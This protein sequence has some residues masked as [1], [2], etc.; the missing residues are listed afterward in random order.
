[1]DVQQVTGVD[2]LGDAIDGG[3]HILPGSLIRPLFAD[4][5]IP[6]EVVTE[7]PALPDEDYPVGSLVFLTVDAKLYRNVDGSTWSRAVDGADLITDSVT[8]GQIAAGAIGTNELA[9]TLVLASLLTTAL[10]G[11]RVEIDAAGIR[12]ISETDELLVNIPTEASE[13]VYV[14]G[15]VD[16]AS[17]ISRAYAELRG[18]ATLAGGSVL[19]V[20][21]GVAA[22]TVPPILT[23]TLDSLTLT[24]SPANA[25]Y[26][27]FY[28]AAAGSFWVGAD[29]T[30]GSYI[31]H[32][33]NATTGVLIRSI[34]KNG[35]I[36]T[37]TATRGQ[38]G[39][40]SDSAE[41]TSGSTDSQICTGIGFPSDG[42][43]KRITRVH[44]YLAG[45]G[46]SMSCKLAVWHGDTSLLGSS[47]AFT[48]AQ[49]TFSAGNSDL[50]E[51]D[52]TA[53]V[54]VS[55][56]QTIY[57]G[58]LRTTG[59]PGFWW[60]KDNS[61]A[62][63]IEGDGLDGPLTN[64][65]T[66]NGVQPNV[67]VTY[68]Y[69]VS[70]QVEVAKIIGVAASASVVAALGAD[71]ILHRYDRS[72]LTYIGATDL[73]AQIG[74]TEANAGLTFDGT[75]F[76]ITTATGTGSSVQVRLVKVNTSGVHQSN[77]NCTGFSING[78]T[79]TIRGGWY[80]GS[81]NF[82][83]NVNGQARKYTYSTGAYVSNNEFGSAASMQDGLA[84][85]GSVFRGWA[86]ATPTKVW[87]F[88]SWD[89]TTQSALY[90][91]GYSWYDSAG[92]THE[93]NLSPRAS[94]TM[95]RRERLRV[96]TPEIPVGGADEPNQVRVYMDRGGTDPGAGNFHR[97]VTDAL[98]SRFLSTFDS[99]GA[100]DPTSNG[101]PAGSPAEVRSSLAPGSGGWSFKGSGQ[102]AMGG[103]SFPSSP[104]T[105]DLFYRTDRDVLYFYDG[106][107]WLSV[108][109]HLLFIN[110]WP[111]AATP[112]TAT[113]ST[114]VGVIP[115]LG[116]HSDIWLETARI[117]FFV[118]GGTALSGSH[119]WDVNTAKNPL[120][121]ASSTTMQSHAI[122]SGT[123]DVWRGQEIAVNALLNSGTA[124]TTI[125][126]GAT[127]TGTPG[128]LYIDWVYMFRFVG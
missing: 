46:G 59:S 87:K 43:P 114:H 128:A 109:Q 45:F 16:A 29:P 37:Y 118:Q 127:K 58:F 89:W 93:T 33:Y 42:Y 19:T 85:D 18:V 21:N 67:W 40:V 108:D 80:D 17:L 106:T 61:G 2:V 26:G 38:T 116:S 24:T 5:I 96:V 120:N 95:R 98:T 122:D 101:F 94:I 27:L 102:M 50:Y 49:K 91:V 100:A 110:S 51:K 47:A 97:Q 99:G 121:S 14:Q 11:R 65:E 71:G 30:A 113:G 73:S 39:H 70:T 111:A 107:R 119:K 82:W 123:L 54:A 7:L 48:A 55:D 3:S 20:E 34:L 125:Q 63:Q 115:P 32:E 41:A 81:T 126:A 76:V 62:G 112:L 84:Y 79:A 10:A 36:T 72:D 52:L 28:D 53:E 86:V 124:H 77:V 22:P 15:E 35:T 74:G 8:A 4:T 9:A 68:E 44:A 6:P 1:M 69:D 60:D 92:T 104:A 88:T 66:V 75:N 78:S 103:T 23:Q 90:W 117:T 25:G 64:I 12:L 13:P 83:V 56:G 57:A 105:N 31:A